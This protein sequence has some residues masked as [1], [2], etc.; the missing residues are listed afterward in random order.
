M[1]DTAPLKGTSV[2]VG[3]EEGQSYWQPLP[4]T[5]YVTVKVSPYTAPYDLFSSGIQVLEPGASIRAHAHER[6]HEMLFVYEGEGSAI[7]DG[8][9]HKIAQGSTMMMGRF[10]EHHIRNE[11]PGQMKLLWVIFPSGLEDWFEA[12]GRP[13][14]PGATTAA[15]VFERPENVAE[16]QRQQRFAKPR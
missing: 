11:G 9:V 16:I 4:S 12:I 15:P 1:N 14:E 3:P 13:R 8:V 6:A 5:G 10:V 7:I 2:V